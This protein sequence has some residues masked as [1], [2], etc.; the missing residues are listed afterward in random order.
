[1]RAG[2]LLRKFEDD[3]E[4]AQG[5]NPQPL[6]DG[7]VCWEFSRLNLPKCVVFH[8]TPGFLPESDPLYTGQPE[9]PRQYFVLDKYAHFF[10]S[11]IL[12]QSSLGLKRTYTVTMHLKI[13]QPPPKKP[14]PLFMVVAEEKDEFEDM[15][16]G[17]RRLDGE[18]RS[19]TELM[20]R[21][22]G[23]SLSR[24]SGNGTITLDSTGQVMP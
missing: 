8:G 17:M 6:E 22:Q 1:M 23:T 3:E 7:S 13:Q 15:D 9:N 11:P 5:P 10:L 21:V 16:D 24:S 19:G 14:F 20:G 12:L 18:W 2:L 4:L